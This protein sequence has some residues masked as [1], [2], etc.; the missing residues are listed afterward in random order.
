MIKVSEDE[1]EYLTGERLLSEGIL[2]L[3]QRHDPQLLLVTQGKDGVSVYR[4]QDASLMQYPAPKVKALDTTGAG[5]AFVA[6]LLAGLANNWPM[7]SDNVWRDI[8][9]QALACG[10]LA[11]TA[12]GAMTALPDAK[13]LAA[14]C[15]Q[16]F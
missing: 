11:T 14:F 3:C 4:K 12:R 6:G 15:G 2:R 5:D 1:L 10:A 13:E 8:V 9:R 16:A 7:A